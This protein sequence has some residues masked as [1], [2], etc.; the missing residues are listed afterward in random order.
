VTFDLDEAVAV[1]ERTPMTLDTLLRTLPERWTTATE[2]PDTWSPF[3]V[4]GHL[5]HGERADWMPRVRHLLA[6]GEAVPFPPF[7]RFAQ[8]EA[9][10]NRSLAELLDLFTGLRRRSLEELRGLAL[11]PADLERPGCHPAFGRVTLEQLLATWVVHD[12]DHLAQISRV[13]GRQYGEAV[14]PWQAYLRIVRT[15]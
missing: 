11:T 15:E 7:D 5:V 3:D 4:I 12:L 10:R 13:M 2:G 9:S 6:H 8:F 1:L 14:G